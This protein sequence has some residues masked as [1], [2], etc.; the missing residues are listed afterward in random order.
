MKQALTRPSE[1]PSLARIAE[2]VEVERRVGELAAAQERADEAVDQLRTM[3]GEFASLKA[4]EQELSG[5]LLSGVDRQKIARLTTLLRERLTEFGFASF[6]IDEV[7]LAE[8]NFRPVMERR[9][10]EELIQREIGIDM[11]ASDG[12]RLKW[13]YYLALL[14]LG[15]VFPTNDPDWSSLM[16]P[17][18]SR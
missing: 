3:A 13:A 5:E 7:V 12:A 9:D 2:I 8:D 18:S 16:S 14:E 11:S 6:S 4:R 1:G 17:D 15:G 10:G